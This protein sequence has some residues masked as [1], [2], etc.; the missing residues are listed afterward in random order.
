MIPKAMVAGA[1]AIALVVVAP[2]VLRAQEPAEKGGGA[3]AGNAAGGSEPEGGYANTLRWTT[4]SEVDNFGFDVYRSL[5]EEGPFDRIT[6]EP[7]PGAG[8]VDE[9][10]SYIYVDDTIDPAKGYYYFIES[11]SIDG[12]R[13]K[14]SPVTYVK[15][16]K[17]AADEAKAA[18]N[19][20]A[21]DADKS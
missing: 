7:I 5:A 3:D 13:E 15:P 9:P 16:K 6:A 20:K 11:I 2:H 17:P 18:G 10:Q 19:G 21:G 1:L 4:A 14:F 8:T 12:I